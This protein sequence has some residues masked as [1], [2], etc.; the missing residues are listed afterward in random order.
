MNWLTD[1]LFGVQGSVGFCM[2]NSCALLVVLSFYL[3]CDHLVSDLLR[4]PFQL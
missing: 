2:L 3:S 1:Q 4:L